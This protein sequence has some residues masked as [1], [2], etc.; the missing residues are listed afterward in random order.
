MGLR[1]L[2][3]RAYERRITA[4]LTP[5]AVPRHIGVILDGNRRWAKQLGA[6]TAEGHRAGGD[7][8]LEFL[9]WCDE[10]GVEVVTLFMLSTDNLV[11][12]SPR[13][14]TDILGISEDVA[15]RIAGTG[16]WHVHPVGALDLLPAATASRLKELEAGSRAN[17]GGHVN[18]AI[19]YGGRREIADAVR[20]LLQSHAAQ[21]TSI[22]ELAEILDVEHIAEHLYTRGQPDPDLVIRTSGEQRLSGF[23]LWQSA[24]SE[25]SFVEALWP[26][27][28][29][30]DFLRALRNY[31]ERERRY[32]A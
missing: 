29:R 25:F 18:I 9:G 30:V 17:T 7:K 5:S 26:D 14:L 31:A 13:E 12:R 2:L 8:I 3:Y 23:L 4:V 6:A 15:A 22:E 24:H 19:G 21:G 16:R 27:F 11:G 28:R 10:L 20:S 32:G 1:Q